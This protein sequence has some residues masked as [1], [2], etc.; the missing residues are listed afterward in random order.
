MGQ[1]QSSRESYRFLDYVFVAALVLSLAAAAYF[2]Y[3]S[4][5]ASFNGAEKQMRA[6]LLQALAEPGELHCDNETVFAKNFQYKASAVAGGTGAATLFFS[7]ET[8]VSDEYECHAGRVD[9]LKSFS[10]RVC[11]VCDESASCALVLGEVSDPE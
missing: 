1:A 7:C 2:T 9:A 4:Y 6:L 11:A 5:P 3:A 10:A 8:L